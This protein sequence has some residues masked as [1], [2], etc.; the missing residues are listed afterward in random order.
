MDITNWGAIDYL[1]LFGGVAGGIVL[2]AFNNSPRFSRA[3]MIV[4]LLTTLI[5]SS[6]PWK[7]LLIVLFLG[8]FLWAFHQVASAE[9]LLQRLSQASKV[10]NK[11][12][13]K[14]DRNRAIDNMRKPNTGFL[15]LLLQARLP[16][17]VILINIIHIGTDSPLTFLGLL[18][19]DLT[20]FRPSVLSTWDHRIA[21]GA[22]RIYLN[23]VIINW[24][25]RFIKLIAIDP[26]FKILLLRKFETSQTEHTRNITAPALSA[27]GR[28]VTV[29]DESFGY[30]RPHDAIGIAKTMSGQTLDIKSTHDW[31]SIVTGAMEWADLVVFEL[32]KV[33]ESIH[34]ELNKAA[35]D[36]PKER[37]LLY[38]FEPNEAIRQKLLDAGLSEVEFVL[39]NTEG[40]IR[41]DT[42]SF[43][44]SL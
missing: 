39:F 11:A 2:Y 14:N 33:S 37:I 42:R 34:W 19:L 18:P 40:Q 13:V 5:A 12:T 6:G 15:S 30:Y 26:Q 8:N 7:V 32:S 28:V 27:F 29:Y 41:R 35:Q 3:M 10:T 38:G 9:L 1:I 24:I 16:F 20:E 25:I 31:K 43:M 23:F 21:D 44:E 4:F 36:V 17:F 22:I